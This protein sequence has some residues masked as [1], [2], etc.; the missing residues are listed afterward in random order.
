VHPASTAIRALDLP[1][2]AKSTIRARTRAWCSVLWP[3][4]SFFNRCRSAAVRTIGRAVAT[5]KAS[6]P[7]SRS[8]PGRS[9]PCRS[10]SGSGRR[11]WRS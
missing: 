9:Q 5:G 11:G 10:R 6:M 3:Q 4:A 2:A 7:I 1:R 8:R